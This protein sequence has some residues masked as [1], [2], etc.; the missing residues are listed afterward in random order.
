M[1]SH[2]DGLGKIKFLGSHRL[3]NLVCFC[4]W[5]CCWVFIKWARENGCLWNHM[6]CAKEGTLSFF[7]GLDHKTIRGIEEKCQQQLRKVTSISSNGHLRMIALG[8]IWSTHSRLSGETLR[9]FSWFGLMDSHEGMKNAR[10]Q[11]ATVTC[12]SFSGLG[13]TEHSGISAPPHMP[14]TWYFALKAV[15]GTKMSAH[16]Q[17]RK[18]TCILSNGLEKKVALGT[19]R[20]A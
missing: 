4:I 15:H 8:A 3:S 12:T 10:R 13:R 17:Q 11:Q 19:N 5:R 6:V 18:A 7:S 1:L 20:H 16:L 9:C 2:W 14:H